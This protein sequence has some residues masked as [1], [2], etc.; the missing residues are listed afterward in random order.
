[1]KKHK[2]YAAAEM[3]HGAFYTYHNNFM[4]SGFKAITARL[5]RQNGDAKKTLTRRDLPGQRRKEN[6]KKQYIT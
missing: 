6:V 5:R 2:V 3:P 1:M 4:S